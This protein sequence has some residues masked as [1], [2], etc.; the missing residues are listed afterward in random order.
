MFYLE[1]DDDSDSVTIV[2]R[3]GADGV[4]IG[5]VTRGRFTAEPDMILT[6]LELRQCDLIAADLVADRAEDRAPRRYF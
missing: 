4:V 1:I 5:R 2:R 3:G 6:P